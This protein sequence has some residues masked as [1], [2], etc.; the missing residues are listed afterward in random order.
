MNLTVNPIFV[1]LHQATDI[2]NRAYLVARMPNGEVEMA[3]FMIH[4]P[5]LLLMID[6]ETG[7]IYEAKISI[8]ELPDMDY[9]L[10]SLLNKANLTH[11]KRL[12]G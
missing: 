12:N 1:E 10:E 5:D 9:I 4:A 6:N 11:I 2:F 8:D 3:K 7:I